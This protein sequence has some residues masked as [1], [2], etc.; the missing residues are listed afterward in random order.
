MLVKALQQVAVRGIPDRAHIPY[1]NESQRSLLTEIGVRV[2]PQP[3]PFEEIQRN[4]RRALSLGSFSFMSCA[5]VAGIPQVVFPLGIV[6]HLTG[7]AIET[8]GVGRWIDPKPENPLEPTLVAEALMEDF[9]NESL[10]RRAK[11]LAP[12]F[13]RRFYPRPEEVVADLVDAI[14]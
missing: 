5:L 2:E 13:E 3:L 9:H 1:A 12:D 11:E 6:K 14:A 7:H 8:L 4:A 10:A